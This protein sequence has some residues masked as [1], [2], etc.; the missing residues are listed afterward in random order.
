M[1]EYYTVRNSAGSFLSGLSPST[2]VRNALADT[3]RFSLGYCH[4]GHFGPYYTLRN[5]AT[6]MYLSSA[7]APPPPARPGASETDDEDDEEL[8]DMRDEVSCSSPTV[9]GDAEMVRE[10]GGEGGGRG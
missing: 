4:D 10:E 5:M 8:R 7:P 1:P 3:E 2:G 6:G 9:G